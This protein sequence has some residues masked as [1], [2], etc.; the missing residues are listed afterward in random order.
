MYDLLWQTGHGFASPRLFTSERSLPT[1]PNYA[2]RH[3]TYTPGDE[4]ASYMQVN[5]WGH[6]IAGIWTCHPPTRLKVPLSPRRLILCA[7][8]IINLSLDNKH[9]LKQ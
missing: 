1:R 4:I 7:C 5:G 3:P 8:E 2:Y 9:L 6:R